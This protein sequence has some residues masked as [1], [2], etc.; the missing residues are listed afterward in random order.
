MQFQVT[1]RS[2]AISGAT[3]TPGGQGNTGAC[4]CEGPMGEE[5]RGGWERHK[6]PSAQRHKLCVTDSPVAPQQDFV[7][8][9]PQIFHFDLNPWWRQTHNKLNNYSIKI[10]QKAWRADFIPCTC[11]PAQLSVSVKVSIQKSETGTRKQPCPCPDLKCDS[12]L[13]STAS[14]I[15]ERTQSNCQ[16][17]LHSMLTFQRRKNEETVDASGVYWLFCWS[18]NFTSIYWIVILCTTSFH[19]GIWDSKQVEIGSCL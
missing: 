8:I 2:K 5:R 13:Q 1:G 6:L 7:N 11:W 10:C 15:H 12:S 18:P 19:R 3:E 9:K 17:S 16:C 14:G 4:D